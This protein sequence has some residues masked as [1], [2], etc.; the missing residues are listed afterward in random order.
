MSG[1]ARCMETDSS[2]GPGINLNWLGQR[3]D[4]QAVRAS[5]RWIGTQRRLR[6]YLDLDALLASRVPR[7]ALGASAPPAAPVEAP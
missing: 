7:P 3:I 1:H 2:H 6:R 4:R 5:V